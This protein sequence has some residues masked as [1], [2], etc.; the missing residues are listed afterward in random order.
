MA[1]T[2]ARSGFPVTR[3]NRDRR[4]AEAI[5]ELIAHHPADT[6][7]AAAGNQIVLTSL[8]PVAAVAAVSLGEAGI[9]LEAVAAETRTVDPT[10]EQAVDAGALTIMA[11]G[12]AA[13]I[14]GARPVDALAGKR[15]HAISDGVG[16]RDLSA[17]AVHARGEN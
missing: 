17:L 2:L 1:G 10:A 15:R 8:A 9:R 12:D 13:Q 16:E 5:A 14:E 6:R 4:E 7:A 11:G 3:C